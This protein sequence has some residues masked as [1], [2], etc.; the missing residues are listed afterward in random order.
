MAEVELPE[1]GYGLSWILAEGRGLVTKT[2]A[3]SFVFVDYETFVNT[4]V[5]Q[6]LDKRGIAAYVSVNAPV[7]LLSSLY[8]WEQALETIARGDKD[9]ACRRAVDYVLHSISQAFEAGASAIVLCDDLC[10]VHSPLVDPR[11]VVEHF[12][13]LYERFAQETAELHIPLIFHA[14]GD[15]RT[16]YE[17]LADDGFAGIHIAHPSFQVTSELFDAAR[18]AGLRPLGGLVSERATDTETEQLAQFAAGLTADGPALICDDG[19]GSTAQQLGTL[20]AALART[21]ELVD[22]R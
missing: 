21:R 11:L 7:G 17:I 22:G 4:N 3:P 20:V 12:L 10:G 13:P 8:G 14:D 2:L 18:A 9:P 5:A 1:S 16:Y 19:A 6:R 15:T